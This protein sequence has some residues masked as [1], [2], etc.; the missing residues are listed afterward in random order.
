MTDAP[1]VAPPTPQPTTTRDGVPVAPLAGGFLPPYAERVHLIADFPAPSAEDLAAADPAATAGAP[2]AAEAL[3]A[4]EAWEAPFGEPEPTHTLVE[5]RELPGPHGPIPVRIYR[6]EPGW[7]PPTP[8]PATESGLRAG[9]VWYHGGAFMGGDLDMPE[10][11]AVARGL[12]TRTGASVVSVFYRLCTGGVHYPVPHDD[13]YA[14]YQWVRGHAAEFGIDA[15]RIAVGGASAGGNLAAGVTLH[16]IDDDAA[17]WQALLAYPVAHGGHWPTPSEE[18]A[19]RLEQMPQI[20]RFPTDMMA[21]MNTN[22]LGAPL[23]AGA[24][25]PA[26]AFPGD[27]VDA[28]RLAGWPATYIENCENDDLRASGEA[29]ARQLRQ[30]GADVE[31]LT[32]AGVPHG[33][34][35]AV[36]SPLTAASLDR[37]AARLTRPV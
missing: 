10:A 35:N 20:L 29:F 33:H 22:Y 4:M 7:A 37:F 21:A 9:L 23:D 3:T 28:A 31:V 34:L 5:D 30:A 27:V 16:G 19:A 13:A 36:G 14:A 15:A 18:L 6:P 17:P 32:C 12:A 8:S 11:D 24:G 2:F 26:Y 25:A 1:G